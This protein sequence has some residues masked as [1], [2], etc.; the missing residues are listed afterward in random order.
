MSINKCDIEQ[1]MFSIM[2]E[3]T[4]RTVVFMILDDVGH[5]IYV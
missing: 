4:L 3:R 1:I 2:I 5:I